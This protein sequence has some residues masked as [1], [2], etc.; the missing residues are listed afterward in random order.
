M[1]NEFNPV[2]YVIV[3]DSKGGKR[4]F[5]A[6]FDIDNSNSL[7]LAE[8]FKLKVLYAGEVKCL[9]QYDCV[10][11]YV[12]LANQSGRFSSEALEDALEEAREAVFA[13]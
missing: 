13:R 6:W 2:N 7:K 9:G 12:G 3:H 5:R 8:I 4:Q 11:N 10:R 1:E